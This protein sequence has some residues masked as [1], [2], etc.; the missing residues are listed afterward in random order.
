MAGTENLFLLL[1][2][3]LVVIGIIGTVMPA[4]PHSTAMHLVACDR[5]ALD[6]Q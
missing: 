4:L 2:G 5:A 1:G 3:A 6:R